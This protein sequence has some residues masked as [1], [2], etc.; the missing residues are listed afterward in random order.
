MTAN[1]EMIE[2]AYR[3]SKEI[4]AMALDMAVEAGKAGAHIGGSFSAIEIFSVLYS[5]ILRYDASNPRWEDRDRFI[6]SKSHCILAN[7]PALVCAGLLPR[8]Q[9]MSFNKNGGLLAGHPWNIDIGLEYPGGSLGMGLGVGIGMALR[10]KRYRKPYRVFVLDGDGESNEGSVWEAVMSAPKFRLDNLTAI[11][12]YNNM[13]FDGVNDSIMPVAPLSD[14]LRAFGW[15]AV[16]V[17][18]HSIEELFD[19]FSVRHEDKP[20]A[21][22][23]HTVKARGIPGLEN[24]AESHHAAISAADYE[25]VKQELAEGKYD[26][27]Q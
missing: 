23:A 20:L 2:K 26:R 4:R 6:P 25:F 1:N 16:D 27:I 10:A 9:L 15:E 14:K 12:D 7:F 22:V 21:I 18:G 8:E 3:F 17:N 5:G 11:F 13:Q 19:A 24:K